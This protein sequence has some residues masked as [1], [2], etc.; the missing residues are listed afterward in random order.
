MVKQLL[1]KADSKEVGS[2]STQLV[3]ESKKKDWDFDPYFKGVL[4]ETEVESNKLLAITGENRKLSFTE[5]LKLVDKRFDGTF[6]YSKNLVEAFSYSP[7][8]T[9]AKNAS[10]I[11]NSFDSH[12]SQL[13][14][15]GYG[16]QI[17][18]TKSLLDEFKSEGMKEIVD[19]IPIFSESLVQLEEINNELDGIYK[20]SKDEKASIENMLPASQQKNIVLDLINDEILPYLSVMS[21]KDAENFKT[22]A[23]LVFTYVDDV[24][25]AIRARMTRAEN[26][27]NEEE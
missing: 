24:N 8:K 27:K 1:A 18:L 22:F 20:L 23:K 2:V 3:E 13:H 6:M 15:L 4:I 10:I 14:R 26:E 17:F 9:I 12:N 16:K 25:T 11:M 7:D 5:G 21:K 19:S